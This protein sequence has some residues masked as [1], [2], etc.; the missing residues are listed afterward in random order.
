[1][2]EP[3]ESWGGLRPA[4]K[5]LKPLVTER[6][7]IYA[8]INDDVL[9]F[10]KDQT[11]GIGYATEPQPDWFEWISVL[12]CTNCGRIN[13][14]EGEV[15]ITDT[16]PREMGTELFYSREET[17]NCSNCNNEI[18]VNIEFNYY[19]WSWFADFEAYGA[20]IIHLEDFDK[21]VK[22]WYK[23]KH[24]RETYKSRT[25]YLSDYIE[26]LIEYVEKTGGYVLLVEGPD[27]ERIWRQI[28][29]REGVDTSHIAITKYG[30]GG[31]TEAIKAIQFFRKPVLKEIPHKLILDSDNTKEDK[32]KELKS[33]GLRE[34]EYHVLEKKEIESYLINTTAISNIMSEEE[35]YVQ[36]L[37]DKYKPKGKEDLDK[38][39]MEILG[40]KSTPEIKALIIRALPEIP[41]ELKTIAEE[42]HSEL[43][44]QASLIDEYRERE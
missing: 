22:E 27:D 35:S 1:M 26:S 12:F 2:P 40:M 13:I 3:D 11:V 34:S 25:E 20:T 14:I 6:G 21:Y 42:I 43:Q 28:L 4:P 32:I 9:I 17:Y 41:E 23:F 36:S 37:I 8:L 15:D 38:L 7:V 19:A 39:F 5:I 16:N 31:I 33:Q 29:Y 24:D 18:D 44:I 10:L 30:V